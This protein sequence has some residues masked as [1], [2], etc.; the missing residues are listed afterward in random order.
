MVIGKL[1][2]KRYVYRQR[3]GMSRRTFRV[4]RDLERLYSF[5][6]LK[7]DVRST[8]SEARV[9]EATASK[10]I[11]VIEA[12]ELE[13]S[14][15]MKRIRDTIAVY[16][17]HATLGKIINVVLH[18]GRRPLSYFRNRF[19]L[20]RKQADRF[21]ETREPTL[22]QKIADTAAGISENAS[23]FVKLFGRL[24]P[25]AAQRR[26][27]RKAE[28]LVP[29]IHRARETF[30]G[31][32]DEAE[33][34]CRIDG[35]KAFRFLCWR[36]DIQVIFTNLI[37]NSLYWIG[38]TKLAEKRI[39]IRIS[40]DKGKLLHVDYT[41]TGPGIEPGHIAGGVIFDPQF[42]TKPDGTGLG[43]A[44]AGEAATRNGLELKALEYDGGAWFRLQPAEAG[45]A[46]DGEQA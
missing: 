28:A 21:M 27:A 38:T 23:D 10:V 37:E 41:D 11:E 1:E 6:A 4:E 40:I 36:Q 39:D 2:E 29:L 44:I 31:Q 3:A 22:V 18:E 33:V 30:S 5:E 45:E 26:S 13:R 8:L 43:L 17:G 46:A 15:T 19:P 9:S 24:D 25:L 42:S 32:M 35:D 34:G 16:Q 14:K 7:R 12:D 20:L